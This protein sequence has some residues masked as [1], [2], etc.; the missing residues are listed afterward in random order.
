MPRH[1]ISFADASQ[2]LMD[3]AMDPLR[4][5][6]AME[7]I[8]QYAGANGALLLQVKGRGPGTPRTRSSD[9]VH[10]VYF[11]D[12]WHLRDERNRG[13][14]FIKTKGVFA[15]Q[16]FAS[17]EELAKSDYYRGFLAKFDC[18]WSAVIGFENADDEW[19]LIIQRGDRGGLFDIEAQNDLVRLAPHLNQAALL[20]RNLA[21]ANATGMIDAY[22][23][24]GC[25][26]F[27]L[28]HFG[29]VIRHNAQAQSLIGDGLDLWRGTLKCSSPADNLAL[30]GLIAAVRHKTAQKPTDP[31]PA[32]LAHRPPKRPLVIH[33]VGLSG[34]ASAIFSPAKSI[35]MVTDTEK[36]PSPTPADLLQK[37]FK[38][39]L[40]EIALLSHLEQEIALPAAAEIMGISFET[41]RSHLKRIFSKTGTSRQTDLLMLMRRVHRGIG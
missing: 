29:K 3:A 6:D 14:P 20:A 7:T 31:L 10:D 32:V 4:W 9:E 8:A 33:A 5:D 12:Q 40:T 15:D 22:E 16:D 2:S 11:R 21:W 18:N 1:P 38:L 27:L 39:T 28:D 37:L 17:R 30:T 23:S 13:L 25:A 19:C 41:A 35:L 34:L 36:R 24:V 26:C